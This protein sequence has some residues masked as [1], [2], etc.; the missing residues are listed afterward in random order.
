MQLVD[1]VMPLVH[2][3]PNLGGA[4]RNDLAARHAAMRAAGLGA[5]HR[6]SGSDSAQVCLQDPHYL[7]LRHAAMGQ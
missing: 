2:G 1:D 4:T 7:H 5:R 6:S 3:A